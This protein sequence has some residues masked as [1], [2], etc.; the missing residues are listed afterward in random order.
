[1]LAQV[2]ESDAPV[3]LSLLVL[4]NAGL[5]FYQLCLLSFSECTLGSAICGQMDVVF[6]AGDAPYR[7]SVFLPFSPFSVSPYDSS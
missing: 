7:L 1:M 4:L 5:E 6:S 2:L 3:N